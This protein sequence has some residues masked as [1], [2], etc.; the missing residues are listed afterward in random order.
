MIR[1]LARAIQVKPGLPAKHRAGVL[2][3]T[4]APRAPVR[5]LRPDRTLVGAL[6]PAV[7]FAAVTYPQEALGRIADEVVGEGVEATAQ[8]RRQLAVV[9]GNAAL[10]VTGVLVQRAVIHARAQGSSGELV[11][12]FGRQMAI[13]GLAGAL[14]VGSDVLSDTLAPGTRNRAA[15][16]LSLGSAVALAQSVALRQGR[17]LVDLPTPQTP[18]WDIPV[19]GAPGY[20]TLR[21]PVPRDGVTGLPRIVR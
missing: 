20:A 2:A 17:R 7:A 21:V 12:S 5:L 11:R 14:V 18:T 6:R 16:A 19:L 8:R 1:A 10:V 15:V 3:A 9:A 13:G 4:S